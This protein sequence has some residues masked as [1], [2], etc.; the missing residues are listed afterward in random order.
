MDKEK[1]EHGCLKEDYHSPY[2]VGCGDQRQNDEDHE[3]ALLD[4]LRQLVPKELDCAICAPPLC[5]G[6]AAL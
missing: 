3:S 2:R 6:T 1:K 4:D 5:V